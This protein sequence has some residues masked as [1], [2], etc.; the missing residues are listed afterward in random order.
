MNPF[1][2]VAV[3]LVVGLLLISAQPVMADDR[4][5]FGSFQNSANAENWAGRMSVLLN[6]EVSVLT[7]TGTNGAT[8]YRVVTAPLPDA[9]A[10]RVRRIADNRQL[11]IVKT[12]KLAPRDLSM[13][14]PS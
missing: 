7:G 14:V 10:T 12:Y 8:T 3:A 11:D 9:E 6:V 2:R 4:L 1:L 5:V 13:F